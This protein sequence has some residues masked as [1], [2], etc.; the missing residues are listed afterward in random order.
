[1]ALLSKSHRR[2]PRAASFTSPDVKQTNRRPQVTIRFSF[3][4]RFPGRSVRD[5]KARESRLG[6]RCD[7]GRLERC[8][9]SRP[10]AA[11][12]RLSAVMLS[13]PH[14]VPPNSSERV[15]ESVSTLEQGRRIMAERRRTSRGSRRQPA[16]P[17]RRTTS[18]PIDHRLRALVRTLARQAARE[19]FEAQVNVRS[20]TIQ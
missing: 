19:A 14:S 11:A 17:A 9:A 3:M 16:R 5:A 7:V 2:L 15:C 20:E 13:E 8:I 10:V 12:T 18:G 6:R 1:M 4:F